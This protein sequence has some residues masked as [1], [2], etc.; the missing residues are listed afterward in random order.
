METQATS[1]LNQSAAP[2]GRSK[3]QVEH[4][5]TG[6]GTKERPIFQVVMFAVVP[7]CPLCVQT[8]YQWIAMRVVGHE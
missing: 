1:A 6:I 8:V 4:A 3:A 5:R 7:D 2:Q